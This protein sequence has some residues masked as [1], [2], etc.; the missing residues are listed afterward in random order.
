MRKREKERERE[1][2]RERRTKSANETNV[3][4]TSDDDDDASRIFVASCRERNKKR[5]VTPAFTNSFEYSLSRR[6]DNAVCGI[7]GVVVVVLL[8]LF[9]F[10]KN[11]SRARKDAPLTVRNHRTMTTQTRAQKPPRVSFP[12][13]RF[14]FVS[15]SW[16]LPRAAMSEGDDDDGT[17]RLFSQ[18]FWRGRTASLSFLR[19]DQS[20]RL[21]SK[22]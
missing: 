17:T 6:E 14:G 15:V 8:L 16:A 1:R 9:F 12:R 22:W 3:I 21:C 13:R 20:R 10:A 19:E 2:E 11:G 7:I 4:S 18:Q 5:S